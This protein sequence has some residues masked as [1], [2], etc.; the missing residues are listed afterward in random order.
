MLP[1]VDF[2]IATIPERK[3]F[4]AKAIESVEKQTYKHVNALVLEDKDGE[5][6]SKTRN[7][8]LDA[9]HADYV[10]V[11]DDDDYL[12]PKYT[13]LMLDMMMKTGVA[14]GFCELM[15]VDSS[16]KELGKWGAHIQNFE[17]MLQNKR[18]PHPGSMYWR[19]FI[20]D[21][22]YDEQYSSAVDLDFQLHLLLSKPAI[23]MIEAPLYYY[24]VHQHRETN[25]SRQEENAKKIREKY[26]KLISESA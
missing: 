3:E 18:M 1:I 6:I 8:L 16:G 4:L 5:G 7:R 22:R 11:L 20:G 9:S 25:K 23:G 10:V 26:A 2:L 12:H 17:Q 19:Q 14:W 13:V 24:R 15:Q 21:V